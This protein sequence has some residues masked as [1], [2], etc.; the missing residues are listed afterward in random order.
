MAEGSVKLGTMDVLKLTGDLNR[1]HWEPLP[2]ADPWIE[3]VQKYLPPDNPQAE[4]FII[5]RKHNPYALCVTV[6]IEGG[7]EIKN[8]ATSV[9]MRRQGMASSLIAHVVDTA[10]QRGLTMVEIG[11]STTSHDQIRL[12]EKCGFQRDGILR[13]HF[14]R[15]PEPIIENGLLA[16]DMLM[17]QRKI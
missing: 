2:Q 1:N 4:I 13:G 16:K 14:L 12:Y 15:Y 9:I 17:L 8:I 7:L 3:A 6:P 11:T 10:Q 5:G